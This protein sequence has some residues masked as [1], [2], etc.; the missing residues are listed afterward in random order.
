MSVCQCRQGNGL[1]RFEQR[2]YWKVTIIHTHNVHEG[3]VWE[4]TQ[5]FIYTAVKEPLRRSGVFIGRWFSGTSHVPPL[6][7]AACSS[8]RA[9]KPG[10]CVILP[11]TCCASRGQNKKT[12][13]PFLSLVKELNVARLHVTI[14]IIRTFIF[15]MLLFGVGGV[16]LH[17]CFFFPLPFFFSLT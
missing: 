14:Q 10:R 8:R 4:L 2:I 12:K 3:A 16:N 6:F 11:A 1:K 7:N 9:E 17:L 15:C 13:N 5:R